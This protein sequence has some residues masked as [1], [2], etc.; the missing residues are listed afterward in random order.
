[1][2]TAIRALDP[3]TALAA[4]TIAR[5]ATADALAVDGL[6]PDGLDGSFLQAG[7]H[8]IGRFGSGPHHVR[9]IRLSG[10]AAQWYRAETPV[11]RSEPL[12]PLPALAPSVWL[13][14]A[15]DATSDEPG[16]AAIAR[17]VREAG[18][19]NWHTVATY[20]GLGY[21]E[22]L[23]A[24]PDGT[25]VAAEAFALDGA[26]LIEAVAV[27]PRFLVVLDQ[28]LVF[29]RAAAL[30]GARLPYVWRDEHGARVGL[31]PRGGGEPRWFPVEPCHVTHVVNAYDDG[32][33]VVLDTIRARGPYRW[34]F[35][36]TSGTVH[37]V[38]LPGVPEHAIVDE[39][40][41]GRRHR[42]VFGRRGH[43]ELVHHD[44]AD[45]TSRTGDLGAGWRMGDPVFAPDPR[46]DA[47]GGG[48]LLFVARNP[49]HG[50]HELRVHDALRPEAP[51]R[52]VVRLPVPL[53]DGWRTVWM[54]SAS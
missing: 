37:G 21:A 18:S 42:H 27:T 46:S 53:P 44:L 19:A 39:R 5:T 3:R 38:A 51:P 32:D 20:P 8:P 23:V 40:V 26:P 14:D 15:D 41:S 48:W 16:A 25:L 50:R 4:T 6:L 34:T 12:R 11:R 30:V 24:A 29:S 35:D 52:A 7:P 33:R 47:E 22:H 2:A 13:G 43:A 17:P 54:P 31:L 36:L 45:G 10:G 9:G 49:S 28:P 1:M